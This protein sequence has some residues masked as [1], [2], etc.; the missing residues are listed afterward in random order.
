MNHGRNIKKNFILL[1][2]VIILLK[3]INS[4]PSSSYA[5]KTD[6][7]LLFLVSILYLLVIF[8]QRKMFG[9]I[10]EP[11]VFFSL[12]LFFFITTF[13]SF[14]DTSVVQKNIAFS[15]GVGSV[16]FYGLGIFFGLIIWGSSKNNIKEQDWFG[17][18]DLALAVLVILVFIIQS[19]FD[20][21]VI[22]VTSICLIEGF[23]FYNIYKVIIRT[24]EVT[25]NLLSNILYLLPSLAVI[26]I[27]L[28][29]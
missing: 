20:H 29:N 16:L 6:L 26:V 13:S 14:A 18:V 28:M 12:S 1:L 15:S 4:F 23:I 11:N 21:S 8:L 25:K 2:F 9:K 10:F 3:V 7:Q 17:G 5:L 19:I 24:V 27:Y 22:E